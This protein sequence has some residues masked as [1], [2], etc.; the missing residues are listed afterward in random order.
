LRCSTIRR[1]S[2][3]RH[4]RGDFDRLIP[5]FDEYGVVQPDRLLI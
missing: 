5:L 3:H 4:S 2:C 1:Q